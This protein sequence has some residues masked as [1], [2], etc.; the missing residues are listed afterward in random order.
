MILVLAGLFLALSSQGIFTPETNLYA[1]FAVWTLSTPL[2]LLLKR[3]PPLLAALSALLIAPLSLSFLG[4]EIFFSPAVWGWALT[5]GGMAL[6]TFE[7]LSDNPSPVFILLGLLVAA[8]ASFTYDAARLLIPN[9]FLM[10]LSLLWFKKA[11]EMPRA[12]S[13]ILLLLV[14]LSPWGLWAGPAFNES[15]QHFFKTRGFI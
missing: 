4:T 5:M 7:L 9:Y 11:I 13:Q 14:V 12:V 2:F 1:F 15:L 10:I 3:L 8:A 6:V